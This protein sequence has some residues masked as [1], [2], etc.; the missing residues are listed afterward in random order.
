MAKGNLF[1]GMAAGSVGDVVF[2]RS[3]GAQISRARN[4]RPSNPK[5]LRQTLQRAILASVSRL[6][7]VGRPIFDHSW[8]GEKV[9]AGSQRGFLHDNLPLLRSLA[10]QEINAA[11]S[12]DAARTRVSAPR[13]SVAVPFDGMKISNGSYDQQLFSRSVDAGLTEFFAAPALTGETVAQYA[14]R[15]GLVAGDLYTFLGITVGTMSDANVVYDFNDP[16]AATPDEYLRVYR[17]RLSYCQLMVREGLS[18]DDTVITEGTSFS[19]FFEVYD[20]S[21]VGADLSNHWLSR[22]VSLISI[23]DVYIAGV[24]G[25]IRSRLDRPD[26]S[27]SYAYFSGSSDYGLTPDVLLDAWSAEGQTIAGTELILEGENFT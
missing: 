7:N 19:A 3:N 6:Y 4:R 13:V 20:A 24:L 26:R 15:N 2:Y 14:A 17:S 5:T 11:T 23:D 18:E 9:G 27:T 12:R 10:V 8:Q 16:G 25:V 21:G 1:L 22:G